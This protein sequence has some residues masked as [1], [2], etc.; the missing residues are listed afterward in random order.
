[1]AGNERVPRAT[2]RTTVRS[3]DGR[4]GGVGSGGGRGPR[5]RS[6]RSGG[7]GGSWK[8]ISD[9]RVKLLLGI[10]AC[11]LIVFV[12]CGIVFAYYYHAY[13][14]V[15]EQRLSQ[16]LFANSAK[17]FAAPREVR[18]DQKYS[19]Q[20]IA[21]D[22]TQ[23]GYSQVGASHPSQLGTFAITEGSI[24]IQPGPQSY[25]APDGA[26]VF[27]SKGVVS[28][29]QA[30]DGQQLSAYELEPQLITGLSD[31]DRGKR[32]LVTYDE[33]PKYLV[34]AVT[35][36]EDRRF[37]EHGAVDYTRVLGA[38]IADLRSRRYSEGSSTLTMQ[39]ARLFFLSPENAGNAKSFRPPLLFSWRIDTRNKK[40]SL[41]MPM[42]CLSASEEVLRS[43]ASA[44]PPSHISAKIFAISTCRSARCWLELFRV[45]A[46]CLP[47]NTLIALSCDAI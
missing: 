3:N 44:R 11:I 40:S 43:T 9:W 45:Q 30:D 6:Y 7:G 2:P 12:I 38:M 24:H 1:M 8:L 46:A 10:A 31:K 47:I 33:L 18:P 15:V 5:S 14:H 35:S 21:K 29:I 13:E 16:P 28:K 25:H 34:P 4:T 26:T 41:S 20:Q 32:R 37:F 42:K 27:T 22:L 36:I 39:V 19:I 17:I 23:A